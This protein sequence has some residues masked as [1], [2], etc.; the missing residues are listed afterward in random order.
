MGVCM[1]QKKM[2]NMVIKNVLQYKPSGNI[3]REI[4]FTIPLQC[5]YHR[6]F[7]SY[8]VG[9][10]PKLQGGTVFKALQ[11]KQSAI[12]VPLDALGNEITG[13]KTYTLGQLMYFMVKTPD[14]TAK[15]G[16]TRIYVNKCFMT[17]TQNPSSSTRHIVISNQG[18]M[19]DGKET[20]Q[21]KFL[22]SSSKL[23]QK[24]TVAAF[25]FTESLSTSGTSKKLY[26]HCEVSVGKLT[27]TSSS[28]ACNYDMAV[29]KWKELYHDDSVCVCCETSCPSAQPKASRKT[30]SS[31]SWRVDLSRD[32]SVDVEPLISD[33]YVSEDLDVA[34]QSDF[35]N[36]WEHDD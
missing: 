30:I 12:L 17:P 28:K 15:S 36:Y 26:M 13:T 11:P 23:I 27:P 35:V 33:V 9:F 21:S 4:P 8:K 1:F 3:V 29:K 6:S 20:A 2:D 5:N 10:Y 14:P 25:V 31:P 7:L 24:F 18:C 32:G 16:N 19:V 22:T 34:E